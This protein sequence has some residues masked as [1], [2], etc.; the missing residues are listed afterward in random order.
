MSTGQL[1]RSHRRG[2]KKLSISQLK[3]SHM[4]QTHPSFLANNECPTKRWTH[5]EGV[6]NPSTKNSHMQHSLL[7]DPQTRVKVHDVRKYATSYALTETMLV[8]ELVKAVG[9]SSSGTSFR[10]YLTK[11]EPL[12]MPV[13]LPVPTPRDQH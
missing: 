10:Y 12:P 9:W 8:G 6:I 1:I 7:G 11:T 13:S 4:Q 5:I 2:L 3:I